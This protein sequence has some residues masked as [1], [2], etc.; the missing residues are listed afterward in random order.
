[1]PAPIDP[2]VSMSPIADPWP[3]SLVDAELPL[4]NLAPAA[5]R[6]ERIA[7]NEKDGRAGSVRVALARTDLLFERFRDARPCRVGGIGEV[8]E[9][10]ARGARNQHQT[11]GQREGRDRGS[12]DSLVADR[13][14]DFEVE[15][16]RQ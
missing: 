7:L 11:D 5:D 9:L 2:S 1:M 14:Q 4:E 10:S 15:V 3:E 13:R 8:D 16:G 12:E 6:A